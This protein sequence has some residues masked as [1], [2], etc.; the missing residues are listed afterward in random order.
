MT[1]ES[2][3]PEE[4]P[5][6]FSGRTLSQIEFSR[7]LALALRQWDEG[8]LITA[9]VE[10]RERGTPEQYAAAVT[11]LTVHDARRDRGIER[12]IPRL[13]AERAD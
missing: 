13:R 11:E 5:L 1:P 9:I 6:K 12:D 4:A 7:L 10:I 8:G 3:R 2:S